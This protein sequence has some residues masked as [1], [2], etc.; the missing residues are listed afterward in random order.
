MSGL[1]G[2]DSAWSQAEQWFCRLHAEDCA[3]GERAAFAAWLAADPAHRRAWDDTRQLFAA[4]LAPAQAACPPATRPRALGR[5]L[6]RRWR[7]AALAVLLVV[8]AGLVHPGDWGADWAT[9]TGERRV[10]TLADGS[11]VELDAASALDVAMGP[12]G[13]R[14]V[15]LRHG[16]AYFQVAADPARPF[17]VATAQGRV[18][19]V[20]TRFS[21]ATQAGLEVAV[22]QGVVELSGA[23]DA[24]VPLR[25]TAGQRGQVRQGHA[26]AARPVDFGVDFAWRRGQM[27]V[28]GQPMAQLAEALDRYWP[29]RLVLVGDDLARRRISG[30]VDLDRPTDGVNALA[31]MLDARVLR[32]TPALTVL[33]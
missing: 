5:R 11:V 20:G 28:R 25:L 14:R 24:A 33:Y 10:L 17:I 9:G 3:A 22:E 23:G 19:V 27:V 7:L 21:V 12:Q 13:E 16:R 30:V 32:L 4:T 15:R 8:L 29:G 26:L 6:A 2:D 1:A 31:Q 18:R